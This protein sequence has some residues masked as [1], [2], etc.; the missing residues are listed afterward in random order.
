[1]NI[2]EEQHGVALQFG[3]QEAPFERPLFA[4]AT[5][6]SHIETETSGDWPNARKARA[7][8]E[9]K[10]KLVHVPY[11]VDKLE[12]Y[13]LEQDPNERNNLLQADSGGFDAV[14]S[15]LRHALDQW[16]RSANPRA[17]MYEPV[18]SEETREALKAL[19]YQ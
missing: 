10:W 19:G 7:I 17:S 3:A 18:Q 16:S 12:L 14:A 1:V 11:Q 13:D 6:P 5:K 9:G 4:E 8:R 2:P 15:R